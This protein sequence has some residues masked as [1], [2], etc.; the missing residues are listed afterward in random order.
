[1][2]VGCDA[3]DPTCD[4]CDPWYDP[5]CGV[6]G[7]GGGGKE[8]CK[9]TISNKPQFFNLCL[10]YPCGKGKQKFIQS[11]SCEGPWDTCCLPLKDKF[12]DSCYDRGKGYVVHET[13]YNKSTPEVDCCYCAE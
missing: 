7:G 9:Q 5:D 13:W 8:T 4:P 1:V 3:S 12:V 11:W 6:A 10:D 2:F